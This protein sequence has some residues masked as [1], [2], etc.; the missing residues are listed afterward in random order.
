MR[1]IPS[2]FT[3]LRLLLVG[4]AAAILII[5]GMWSPIDPI[6]FAMI[7]LIVA[8][9][10]D[11]IVGYLARKLN[12]ARTWGGYFDHV[13]DLSLIGVLLYQG[14]M[15]LDP[16]IF[17]VY[18]LFQ[19]LTMMIGYYHF[20]VKVDEGWPN[21]FGKLSYIIFIFGVCLAMATSG[22]SE[23]AYGI[24]SANKIVGLAIGLRAM[25]FW[26][27]WRYME[28]QDFFWVG[29]ADREMAK[30]REQEQRPV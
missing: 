10:T 1:V 24:D 19:I 21:S 7:I 5:P 14:Y 9:L 8:A 12:V 23:E 18:V 4:W 11:A 20:L 3:L 15:I 26:I 13:V 17:K 28:D 22:T 2:S 29:K 6:K 16:N 25:S 30:R 27:Y